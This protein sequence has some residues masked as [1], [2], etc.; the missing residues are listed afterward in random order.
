YGWM[1][2]GNRNHF[3]QAFRE[4]PIVGKYHFTIFAGRR[5]LTQRGVVIW[6]SLQELLI[7]VDSNTRVPCSVPTGD[8]RRSVGAAVIY[9]RI[10]PILIGLTKNAF[11]AFRQIFRSIVNGSDDAHEGLRCSVHLLSQVFTL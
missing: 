9:D 6:N 3:F 4:N 10:L 2:F 5:N 11:Y 7:L 1:I 8:F